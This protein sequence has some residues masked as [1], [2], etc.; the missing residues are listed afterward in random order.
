MPEPECDDLSGS[1]GF[2]PSPDSN[3]RLLQGGDE[4][5][6]EEDAAGVSGSVRCEDIGGVAG[7]GKTTLVREKIAADPTWGRLCATTGIAAVNLDAV[8]L[9]SALRFFDTDSLRDAYLTGQLARSLHNIA[10]EFRNLVIDEKSMLDAQQL[11]L[12]YRATQQANDYADVKTPMGIILVGDF[13]QLP[14]VE[15]NFCFEAECW[16]EFE[17]N[18]THL[19]KIWRQDQVEFIDALNATRRG[20]GEAAVSILSSA[21]VQWHSALD[22]D[23]D[24]TTLVSKNKQVDRYNQM[25]LDQHRGKK[26]TVSSR[27]WGTLRSEWKNIPFNLTLKDGCYVM[28]LAN[29]VAEFGEGEFDYVN[30]DCGRIQSY[31]QDGAVTVKLI[32]NG[33]IVR[34]KSLVRSVTQKDR[35]FGQEEMSRDDGYVARVH[36]GQRGWVTGQVEYYPIRL[37]YASTVHKSQGVSLDR[38]QVD[39]RDSFFKTPSMIYVALSRVRT[40]EGLRI[41][42]QR[43]RFVMYCNSDSRIQ[44]WL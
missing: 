11:D 43:E 33:R 22:I 19:T 29:H 37:A 20:D 8:T 27:R 41:V 6:A 1:G 39:I 38:L 40:L 42:G 13:A 2:P 28:I 14:P 21:G 35:P 23:Y 34:V 9:N 32:R 18:R 3:V 26:F 5:P 12:I 7:T 30:G 31:E 25:K 16:P 24:G 44:R 4:S 36:K 17:R 10:L 15:G